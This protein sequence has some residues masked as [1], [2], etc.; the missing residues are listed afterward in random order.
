MVKERLDNLGITEVEGTSPAIKIEGQSIKGQ[1]YRYNDIEFFAPKFPV[2]KRVR[3][4]DVLHQHRIELA[5]KYFL[6]ITEGWLPKQTTSEEFTLKRWW[7]KQFSTKERKQFFLANFLLISFL[8]LGFLLLSYNFSHILPNLFGTGFGAK[9]SFYITSIIFAICLSYSRYL[10]VWVSQDKGSGKVNIDNAIKNTRW[11]LATDLILAVLIAIINR[12]EVVN[13][14]ES[15]ERAEAIQL[16]IEL[17][18]TSFVGGV[19]EYQ[20]GEIL[21]GIDV[22]F[23]DLKDRV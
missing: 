13:F 18:F 8:T 11:L 5:E 2:D 16:L 15:R 21:K 7:A 3:D 10:F 9:I 19:Y 20:I 22:I 12:K 1:K 6:D 14:I 17:G 23:K 4:E